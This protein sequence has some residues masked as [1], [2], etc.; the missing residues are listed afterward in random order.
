MKCHLR[1]TQFKDVMLKKW[2]PQSTDPNRGFKEE[3]IGNKTISAEEQSTL[4][5]DMLESI[6]SFMPEIA[7][8]AVIPKATSLEWVYNLLREH[9]GCARTGRDMMHKFKTLERKPGERLRAYWSRYVAF[10]EENR[11][12]SGDKLKIDSATATQTEEQCRFSQSSELV[13]FLFMAH[14]LLPEKMAGILHAKLENQDVA[15]LKDTITPVF[16]PRP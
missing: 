14:R 13:L 8:S 11:I 3:K 9:Y 15:S 10:F 6:I 12:K 5:S 2:T 4:V 16:T 1:T 7:P